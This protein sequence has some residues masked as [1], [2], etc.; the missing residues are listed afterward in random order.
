MQIDYQ[1][2]TDLLKDKIILV[3]GA[4][5]GLG[6]AASLHFARAGATVIL[7]GRN[8]DNL[9]SIYD[10]IVEQGYPQPAIYPLDLVSANPEQYQQLRQRIGEEFGRLDGILHNAG[11][12]GTLT[13]LEHYDLK[14]WYTVT[15]LNLHAPFLLTQAL[16]PLLRKADNGSIVF[17][18]ADE[19]QQGRAYWGA[20][21]ISKAGNMNLM[22]ILADELENS[23]IRVNAITPKPTET[24]LRSKAY[25]A[26]DRSKLAQ[27]DDHMATYLYLM[28]KDSLDA[29]GCNYHT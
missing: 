11:M 10:E 6:R 8:V 5:N 22:Q 17:T 12:L 19:G 28:G 21:G 29:N 2:P 24:N 13:P 25:P 27:V 15:Q 20:Y 3:T 26:E 7:L 4:G 16:I 23:S 9:K 14:T 18:G 1:A